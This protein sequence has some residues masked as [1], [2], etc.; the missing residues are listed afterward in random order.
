MTEL[1]DPVS[2]TARLTA[3][4]RARESRR[5]DRLFTDPWAEL[6]AGPAGDE[7]LA[8]F[9]NALSAR[10]PTIPVRTRFFDDA[11]LDAGAEGIRQVV[12]VAAGMDSRA[13]RLALPAGTTV[14]ELD[15]PDLLALKDD[16]LG[17]ASAGNRAR[18]PVGAD[19]ARDWTDALLAA[20]FHPDR[21]VCWLAEGLSQYLDEDAL[22]GLLD[23]ITTL[24][25]PGSRAMMDFVGTSLLENP[26]MAP[27]LQLFHDRAMTW[28]YGNETPEE[29]FTRRGW[30]AE[31]TRLGA[32]GSQLGRWPFPDAPRGTPGVPQ[33]YLIT[34]TK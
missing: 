12:L 28:K 16:L 27:M 14:Y 10:I 9:E 34:A 4:E 20:G 32:A 19:L 6:L 22:L 23:R 29:L 24:S 11:L 8:E 25:A 21:P 33:G 26:A 2:V 18:V 13:F 3:A 17:E 5:E 1:F 31:A 30:H 7:L 15:R